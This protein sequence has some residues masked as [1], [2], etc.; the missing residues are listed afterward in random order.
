MSI[1]YSIIKGLFHII[2]MQRMMAKSYDE[3]IKLF[4]TR[5]AKPVIPE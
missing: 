3:L 2:P 4:K 1:K 5:E